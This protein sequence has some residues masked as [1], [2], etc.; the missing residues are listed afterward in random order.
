MMGC[1]LSCRTPLGVDL[2]E[3]RSHFGGGKSEIYLV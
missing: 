1:S 2:W 3:L